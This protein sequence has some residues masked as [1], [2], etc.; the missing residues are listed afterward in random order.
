[1]KR[2]LLLAA[3]TAAFAG[4]ADD[5]FHP[6][7]VRGKSQ[8]GAWIVSNCGQ[9]A[10]ADG[11]GRYEIELPVQGVY[12]LK[13]MADGYEEE[14]RP[15][16]EVPAKGDVDLVLWSRPNPKRRV[17]HGDIGHPAQL[18]VTDSGL[19]VTGF[20]L[21]G[22]P[23]GSFNASKGVWHERNR[24]FW[25]LGEYCFTA[26]GQV[27]VVE[28]QDFRELRE[29]GW[30]K[31]DFHAHI[32]HYENFY[33][34]NLQQ[35]DFVCRAE[36]F[37]WIYLASRHANDSYPVDFLSLAEYLSDDKLFLRVNN[38]FPKNIYGHFGSVNCPPLS[39]RDFGPGYSEEN[40]TNL[41]LAE[42]T[43]YAKGGLSIPVHPIYGDVVHTDSK[44]G[45]KTY[46]MIN[47]ELM[48]WLLCRPDLVPV[49]DFFYFP[50]DR[51]ER[52]WYRLL[53]KGY[54]LACSG[55]SDAAFDVGRTPGASHATYARLDKV[56]GPSIAE[57][58]RAGR[59]MV[60]YRGNAVLFDVDGHSSGD[61]IAPGDVL[62]RMKVDTYAEPGKRFLVRVVRNGKTFEER[63]FTAPETGRFS[64]DAEFVEN[65]DAWYV[66]TLREMRAN[67]K[68]EIVSA[69]SPIYFRSA[70]FR[71]PEIVPLI[72]PL[73]QKIKER[74]L[75]LS[76]DEVDTDEWYEELK[77]MLKSASVSSAADAFAPSGVEGDAPSVADVVI[78]G[79]SPAAVTA[80]VKAKDMGLTP[81]IVSPEKHVGG[82]SVS[83]LGFTDS[84]NTA[85]I[86][87]LAREF[88]HRIY[89]AY[90]KP[91]AWR[92]QKRE[93]FTGC[94]Q[95]TKAVRQE[96][97]TMWTFEPHIAESV[98]SE[99]LAEK[100]VKVVCCE[101]LD[102]DKGVV[103]EN[104]RIVS[105]RMLSGS[106][107]HGRYFIDATYEGDLMAASGVPYRVGR[108]AC[109]EFGEEW[110][111][112]QV[113]ILHHNHNFRDWNI[114]PYRTPGD[115]SSGLCAEIDTSGPGVRGQA[116]GLVQAYCY[117]LCMTDDPRNRIPFSKPDGYDSSR[118]ELLARVYAKGYDETF[119]K[120]DRIPNHKTDTNN[121]GPFNADYI[122]ASREWPEA[123]YERRVRIAQAH[124]DYQMGLYY[125]L[126]NDPSVPADVR[127]RMSNWGLAS[128]EFVDNGGWPYHL[129][130]R[131]ARRMQGEYVMT[132]HDCLGNP[133]HPSQGKAYGSIGMGSYAIDSHNVRRYVTADGYVQNEGDIGVQPKQPYEIDYGSIIP[134][135]EDCLNLL[136]PVALSATHTAFG[137]IR[138]EPVFMILGESA[139]TAVALAAKDGLAVQD[140]PYGSLKARL[141]ADGQMLHR[142]L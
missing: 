27:S 100:G 80:A 13:A 35:M 84:G 120:F 23:V 111:G 37:D 129:Y 81:V 16:L 49:V 38:E 19:P 95:G 117:R 67:G 70:A 6:C 53:D 118:Y 86:G 119:A 55:S 99:W 20:D 68:T 17:V 40:V 31:G 5:V 133:R 63:E 90:R 101:F 103:K 78:Y 140:V 128:D 26:T 50:E 127:A 105:I 82:L 132:E 79:S 7:V 88:Y 142:P 136:V 75:Y 28:M 64:F 69:A 42:R 58:F 139:A 113:G 10:R 66:A 108:E 89:L 61:K 110:N 48:L 71:P 96:D 24:Y 21:A 135:R 87:G 121:H 77:G 97:Q 15:W 62:R 54:T 85:A 94:G 11:K 72:L 25:T 57:A 134:R 131:E 45:R 74:I 47:N 33:K 14:C 34:A 56:D 115:P 30:R 22:T 123:S 8:P 125:F 109:S 2:Q 116:D 92:W 9:I 1:M 18:V 112:N 51:A 3:L 29:R 102:R 91:D 59:T 130:V 98:F 76:P 39:P 60:S 73:P 124:R 44:T 36:R 104:G 4:I 106:V 32:V 52:F 107:Y 126:A 65:D 43:V 114:S 93:D 122:G 46:G 137:S 83:G 138:M 12:C 41:E 141:V